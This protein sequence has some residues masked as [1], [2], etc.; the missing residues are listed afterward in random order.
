VLSVSDTS[1]P[2]G[3]SGSSN[4]TLQVTLSAPSAA[5]VS[6][7]YATANGTATAGSDYTATTGTLSFAP[8]AT[9]GAIQVPVLG[10]TTPEPV[11]TF[12][13]T[14][15]AP[16]SATLGD[17]TAIAT[18]VDDDG[19]APL[20]LEF[21]HGFRTTRDF[22]ASATH[23]YRLRQ[24][25]RS[26]YEVVV[27]GLSGNVGASGPLLR[28]LASDLTTVLSDSLPVGAGSSRSLAF[29]NPTGSAV[30]SEY[31]QIQSAGCSS[32]T[33]SDAYRVRAYETTMSVARFN[34]SGNQFSVLVL[35]NRAGRTVTGNVHL[36][37]Q[38][39]AFLASVP[40]TLAAR[41][42]FVLNT[43]TV[44]AAVGQGGSVT[45]SHNGRYGD[46]AGKA[47]A[48]EPST[49]FT[50]DTPLLPRPR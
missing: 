48:V 34:N 23:L 31:V 15:S 8:G 28:R 30:Q 45:V 7:S 47:V 32:C 13:V 27:D 38:P 50:F 3:D 25:P 18:I 1:V 37:S 43:A 17:A 29:E 9:S 19:G 16:V 42:V 26:S 10:D 14:L 24:A 39:G 36:W 41:A 4:A 20:F 44:P 49:G 11:E 46:L 2:E 33:P 6:V 5:Q 12:S 35:E 21:S 22:D 40:F